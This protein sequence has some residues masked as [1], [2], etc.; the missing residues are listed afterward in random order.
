MHTEP[1]GALTAV[2]RAAGHAGSGNP[3]LARRE[4]SFRL[5]DWRRRCGMTVADVAERLGVSPPKIS[6]IEKAS[7]RASLVDVRD[8]C[9]VYGV[10]AAETD[11]LLELAQIAAGSA[12]YAGVDYSPSLGALVALE[13]AARAIRSFQGVLVPALLQTSDY[14]RA[15]VLAMTDPSGLSA[16]DVESSSQV[17]L[18]Q[19]SLVQPSPPYVHLV[20]DESALRRPLGSP[21]VMAEQMRQILRVSL[22]GHVVLQVVPVGYGPHPSLLGRFTLLDLP[23]RSRSAVCLEDVFDRRILWKQ[24]TVDRY[25]QLFVRLADDVA[26]STEATRELVESHLG[27]WASRS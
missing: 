8:L 16:R 18:R 22:L 13:S 12:W 6:R 17:R 26:L 15:N 24:D 7:R 19:Q 11:E 4:L 5:A 14:A 9:R 2:G 23:G 1:V 27:V 10:P 25:R 21:R 3:E 20:I